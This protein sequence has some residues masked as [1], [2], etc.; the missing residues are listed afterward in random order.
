MIVP[1][2]AI[3]SSFDVKKNVD[4]AILLLDLHIT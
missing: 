4:G 2:D 3:Y 1:L